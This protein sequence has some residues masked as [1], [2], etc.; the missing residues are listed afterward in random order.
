MKGVKGYDYEGLKLVNH[1]TFDFSSSHFHAGYLTIV[2]NMKK[3]KKIILHCLRIF[4]VVN[5]RVNTGSRTEQQQRWSKIAM[6]LG[7]RN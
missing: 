7:K 6:L 5:V 2:L 4:Y 3:K 1:I